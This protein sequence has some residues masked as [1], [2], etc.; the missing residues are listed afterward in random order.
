MH[1]FSADS[2]ATRQTNV[3]DPRP[4]VSQGQLIW[5]LFW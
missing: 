2:A 3:Y 4:R 1:G 5:Q